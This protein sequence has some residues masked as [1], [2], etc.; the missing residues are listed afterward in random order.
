MGTSLLVHVQGVDSGPPAVML[1]SLVDEEGTDVEKKLIELLPTLSQS[2]EGERNIDSD[3]AAIQS[4]STSVAD[5]M[6]VCVTFVS[7][8]GIVFGHDVSPGTSL[9]EASKQEVLMC[10][11][12]L[13]KKCVNCFPR[14]S[15]TAC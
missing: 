1:V 13:N 9:L 4:H 8:E 14:G 12:L 15:S 3:S 5:S 6:S 11:K 2:E 10:L 7:E